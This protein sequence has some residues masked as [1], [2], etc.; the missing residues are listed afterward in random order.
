MA[1]SLQALLARLT[2]PLPPALRPH[3]NPPSWAAP[4]STT[5]W[6]V[7][8]SQCTASQCT[9][10]S[11][12]R[13]PPF[14]PTPPHQLHSAPP[15]TCRWTK[16]SLA[17]TLSRPWSTGG[18]GLEPRGRWSAEGRAKDAGS[19][20]WAAQSGC[21]SP[22]CPAPHS[23]LNRSPP[24]D[25]EPLAW[26]PVLPLLPLHALHQRGAGGAGGGRVFGLCSGGPLA[27]ASRRLHAQV[28]TDVLAPA[29]AA[30][31]YAHLAAFRGRVL[32][33]GGAQLAGAWADGRC[34]RSSWM[35]AA[36]AGKRSTQCVETPPHSPCSLPTPSCPCSRRSRH[37]GDSETGSVSSG[38]G[39]NIEFLPVSRGAGAWL[40]WWPG[41][42]GAGVGSA[43]RGRWQLDAP[44]RSPSHPALHAAA[45]QPRAEQAGEAQRGTAERPARVALQAEAAAAV[46]RR[47]ASRHAIRPCSHLLSPPSPFFFV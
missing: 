46:L 33:R 4:P 15:S 26:Q 36:A 38:G 39:A 14:A 40:D 5:C 32:C 10:A 24:P 18:L 25:L 42:G 44:K 11:P 43:G 30:R 8:A 1:R 35:Q 29:P 7:A 19:A 22:S 41:R 37:A 12:Q 34:W 16:T 23:P 9:R 27:A 21:V 20:A 3:T 2:D 13:T 17:R 28:G 47:A 31:Q 45:G 6:W